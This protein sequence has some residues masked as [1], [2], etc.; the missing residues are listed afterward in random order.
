M[1][2]K[3]RKTIRKRNKYTKKRGGS[4]LQK[5]TSSVKAAAEKAKEI[6]DKRNKLLKDK[7]N[8]RLNTQ[9]Q[10]V[11]NRYTKKHSAEV[12]SI[13]GV[14]PTLQP[15][16]LDPA[17]L[18][19]EAIANNIQTAHKSVLYSGEN[20]GENQRD[21]GRRS[22]P[23]TTVLEAALPIA[24][25]ASALIPPAA[26]AKAIP[27]GM[28]TPAAMANASLPG[29]ST[30]IPAMPKIP[31]MPAIPGI[32]G[33]PGGTPNP[34]AM[35]EELSKTV[36]EE[37]RKKLEMFS[38]LKAYP[39]A[40][41]LIKTYI[42]YHYNDK[43]LNK[44][45]SAASQL[46]DNKYEDYIK[47]LYKPNSL[48][49]DRQKML[50]TNYEVARCLI[51][52]YYYPEI[53]KYYS[54]LRDA[55]KIKF[56][57]K[58]MKYIDIQHKLFNSIEDKDIT[59]FNKVFMNNKIIDPGPFTK[60]LQTPDNLNNVKQM[61]ID[62]ENCFKV[63]SIPTDDPEKKQDK[64]K[65]SNYSYIILDLLHD[66][67]FNSIQK[68]PQKEVVIDGEVKQCEPRNDLEETC[69]TQDL[70]FEMIGETI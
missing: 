48:D 4:V 45:M 33:L 28:P 20:S 47:F 18:V 30:V 68:N 63:E 37:V 59:D 5:I 11:M 44:I 39:M 35:A 69:D 22:E 61:R 23:V 15:Q 56:T 12:T 42:K 70:A 41:F 29:I 50:K 13:N 64:V 62:I 8:L 36:K 43:L 52:T 38:P 2:H 67:Y 49:P 53:A 26:M 27:A 66:M 46:T 65:I 24:F 40:G 9:T 6:N 3:K 7:E 17:M 1:T 55:N 25:P 58:D 57:C 54:Y 16:G 60:L 51:Y 14:K 31:G 32:P 21:R 19:P 34:A 10:K